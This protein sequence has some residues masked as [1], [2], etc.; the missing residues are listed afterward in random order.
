M[1]TVKCPCPNS[2]LTVDIPNRTLTNTS[3]WWIRMATDWCLWLRQNEQARRRVPASV[4]SRSWESFIPNGP[5]NRVERHHKRLL[6][7][8]RPSQRITQCQDLLTLV[9]VKLTLSLQSVVSGLEIIRVIH[10]TFGVAAILA[11]EGCG[12]ATLSGASHLAVHGNGCTLPSRKSALPESGTQVLDGKNTALR[13]RMSALLL[14][15]GHGP[16]PVLRSECNRAAAGVYVSCVPILTN[17][18]AEQQMATPIKP[19]AGTVSQTVEN[20]MDILCKSLA[21]YQ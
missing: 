11:L 15:L 20:T 14:A 17:Q 4:L 7:C 12:V 18:Q 19:A 13:L 9:A 6:S 8:W 2:R 10:T 16:I 21:W 5:K 1:A 3:L